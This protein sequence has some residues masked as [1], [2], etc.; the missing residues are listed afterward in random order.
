MAYMFDPNNEEDKKKKQDVESGNMT[1]TSGDMFGQ[2]NNNHNQTNNP[3]QFTDYNKINEANKDVDTTS[4]FNRMSGDISGIKSGVDSAKQNFMN[5]APSRQ[6]NSDKRTMFD[7]VVNNFNSR[8]NFDT[9]KG[10][11]NNE[12]YSGPKSLDTTPFRDALQRYANLNSSMTTGQGINNSLAVLNP[13][14]S[15]GNNRFDT[16]ILLN[17]AQFGDKRR[18][19]QNSFLDAQKYAQDAATEIENLGKTRANEYQTF[20]NDVRN[21]AEGM[22]NQLLNQYN[23]NPS[24]ENVVGRLNRLN[25]LMGSSDRFFTRG[26]NPNT[27]VQTSTNNRNNWATYLQAN[28]DVRAAVDAGLTTAQQHYNDFGKNEGRTFQPLQM[29]RNELNNINDGFA[30][31]QQNYL[32]ANPDVK[33]AID[34]GEFT[35]AYQHFMQFGRGENREFAEGGLVGGSQLIKRPD[36]RANA[37][38]SLNKKWFGSE[39]FG[40]IPLVETATV[41]PV[42]QTKKDESNPVQMLQDLQGGSDPGVMGH[43]NAD[44]TPNTSIGKSVKDMTDKELGMAIDQH[45]AAR[46]AGL[47]DRTTAL[48][49]GLLGSALGMPGVGSVVSAARS[50]SAMT[51]DAAFAEMAERDMNKAEKMSSFNDNGGEGR[52]GSGR[53]SGGHM[54]ADGREHGGDSYGGFKQGGLVRKYAEGGQLSETLSQRILRRA[55]EAGQTAAETASDV[56]NKISSTVGNAVNSAS[57][58]VGDISNKISDAIPTKEEVDNL[59]QMIAEAAQKGGSTLS[60]LRSTLETE[61][62]GMIKYF[63]MLAPRQRNSGVSQEMRELGETVT[64]VNSFV[65]DAQREFEGDTSTP[66]SPDETERFIRGSELAEKYHNQLRTRRMSP[67]QA[68]EF[69]ATR[70][71]APVLAPS[72]LDKFR[73]RTQSDPTITGGNSFEQTPSPAPSRGRTQIQEL[74]NRNKFAEGGK[75]DRYTSPSVYKGGP[76]DDAIDAKLS[77]NE[78]VMRSEAVNALGVEN[79]EKINRAKNLSP[80]K[81]ALKRIK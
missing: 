16:A 5:A 31:R 9:V 55:R 12:T 78:F 1:S 68:L 10:F 44:N 32:D 60:A 54:G 64:P 23:S 74:L 61:H 66:M 73:S 27:P 69:D 53:D 24:D 70:Q 40:E 25:E 63:D 36:A 81:E 34:R 79:M 58:T 39:G 67:E 49:V 41:T 50:L 19:I 71:E 14:S 47:F 35:N 65:R 72:A 43:F 59:K 51:R 48:G 38:S 33:A 37:L 7:N 46:D 20:N 62:P 4:L 22:R 56:G 21:Y 80:L 75:V 3:G 45:N 6:F 11:F 76:K 8:D 2:T 28:P 26:N 17:N 29:T 42:D 15:R 57:E 77:T 30:A 13:N 52:E 18:Q